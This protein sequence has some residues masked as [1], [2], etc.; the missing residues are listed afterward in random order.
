MLVTGV[1]FVRAEKK[2]VVHVQY[3]DASGGD[4]ERHIEVSEEW[5]KKEAQF[6]D[7][8]INHMLTLDSN[9]WY[10]PLPA[11][12][13]VKVDNKTILQVKS[14]PEQKCNVL[15]LDKVLKLNQIHKEDLPIKRLPQKQKP[16][17]NGPLPQKD[18]PVPSHWRVVNSEGKVLAKT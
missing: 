11:D 18:T 14:V 5:A 16:K 9:Q 17:N 8:V 13:Q 7:D 2:F 15:D 6:A 10:F 4:V 1:K 3:T 12:M